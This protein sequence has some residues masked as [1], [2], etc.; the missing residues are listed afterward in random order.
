VLLVDTV[1]QMELTL[2]D[3]RVIVT[4]QLAQESSWFLIVEEH[5]LW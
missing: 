4:F 1:F 2:Q 3:V 5:W